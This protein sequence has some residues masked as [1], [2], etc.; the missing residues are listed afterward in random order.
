MSNERNAGRKPTITDEQLNKIISRHE[1]G[2]NVSTLLNL[3]L[4]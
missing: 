2:K 1:S 3:V 4:K